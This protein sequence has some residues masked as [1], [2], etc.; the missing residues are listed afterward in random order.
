MAETSM[1]PVMV[2]S[3]IKRALYVTGALSLYHRFRNRGALTVVM[4]HRVLSPQDPRWQS[5]DPDYTISDELFAQCLAFFKRHYTIVSTG[6]MLDARRNGTKLPP[7][8]LLVTFDDGWADTAQYALPRL[9]S[10]GVPALLF[11]IADVV[12]RCEPFFQEQLIGAWRLGRVRPTQI[13]SALASVDSGVAGMEW[14]DDESSLRRLIAKL[15]TMDIRA[16]AAVLAP[17]AEELDDGHR[18]WVTRDELAELERGDVAI[19]MHGKTHV[20]MTRAEDLEAELSG[21]RQIGAQLRA[22]GESPETLSFPHGRYDASIAQRARGAGYELMFTSVQ[23]LNPRSAL[24]WLL[25]RC[26]FETR[27]ITDA[28]NRFRPELL[29]LYLFRKPHR[30]L[31]SD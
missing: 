12:G 10:A 25:G 7:H 14:R 5:C 4:F 18:H 13:A 29:G 21:A 26:G 3:L 2:L 24:P 30:T 1:V 15:E 17:F 9:K 8:A 22:S 11:L 31:A 28:R 19:G 27:T 23:A 20:P 6:Q 16:R